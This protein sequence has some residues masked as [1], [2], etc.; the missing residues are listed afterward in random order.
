M[1]ERPGEGGKEDSPHLPERPEG[2]FAQ[3]GTVLPGLTCGAGGSRAM[4]IAIGANHSG[5][6]VRAMLINVLRQAGHEVFDMGVH[7]SRPVDY[8]DVAAAV[9]KK[10][11][12]GEAERGIL[13]GGTGLGCALPRI[14]SPGSARFLATTT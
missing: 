5:H 12:L 9:A 8:P 11:V 6:Q 13:I 4:Q 2:C 1:L 3:M 10:V 7:D 14:S